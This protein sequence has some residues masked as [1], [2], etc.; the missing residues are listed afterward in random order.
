MQFDAGN[1]ATTHRCPTESIW[2]LVTE[3]CSTTAHASASAM[4]PISTVSI[5]TASS[6]GR[7]FH[8]DA[9]PTIRLDEWRQ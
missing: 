8:A 7:L 1:G 4:R 6:V 5:A 9:C 3:K 2:G